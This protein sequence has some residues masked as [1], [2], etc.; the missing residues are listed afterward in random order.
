M[1]LWCSDGQVAQITPWV[2][3]PPMARGETKPRIYEY[4]RDRC[5]LCGKVAWQHLNAPRVAPETW[6]AIR[7]I[8]VNP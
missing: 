1:A 7:R 5:V 3:V 6:A 2:P 8:L 4:E